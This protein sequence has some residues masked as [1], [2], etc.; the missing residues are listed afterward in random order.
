MVS[1]LAQTAPD[2]R[3]FGLDLQTFFEGNIQLINGIILAVALSWLL[4]KPVKEF[5]S[6]RTKRIQ[7]EIDNSDATMAKGNK[8]I[9]EYDQKIR[10]IDKERIEILEAARLAANDESK[11]ILAEAREE[12]Q[13]L[14][15]RSLESVSK[16]K[17]RLAEETRLYIIELASIIAEKHIVENID[18]A[19]QTKIFEETLAELEET[20]WQS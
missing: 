10:D 8:L 1:L 19:S 6:K 11:I 12:A 4:Y 14:K 20:Q 17:E 9:E 13:D 5:L 7:D 15:K 2:G 16:E 3:V 18:Q